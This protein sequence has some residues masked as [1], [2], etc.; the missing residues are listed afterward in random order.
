MFSHWKYPPDDPTLKKLRRQAIAT[1]LFRPV[2]LLQAVERMGFVQA[3]PIRSPA[4][5]QD[6]ILRHRVK[7]Y[8][9][10]DLESQYPRLGLEEDFLYA[11]GFM[12]QS[13]WRLLH[14]RIPQ[15]LSATEKRVLDFVSGLKQIHPRDLDAEFGRK[16]E[17]NNWGGQ[18]QAMTRTLHSL[19]YRGVLRVVE[20]RN[21]IRLYEPV[22]EMHEPLDPVERLRQLTLL[23][24]SILAP[25]PDT[26]LRS[27]VNYLRHAAPALEGRRS[28]VTELIKSG[29]LA[30]LVAD[31]VKYVWPA[32][33]SA[34]R[35]TKPKESVRFLAPFDPLVWDRRRFEHFWNWAYRFEAYTPAAKRQLGYY[36]M[37]MLWRDDVIGWVN[38]VNRGGSSV[39][40]PGFRTVQPPDSEFRTEF[41]AEVARLQVFLKKRDKGL[42]RTKRSSPQ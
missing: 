29:D 12:P 6:L 39:V 31:G 21:G 36:A 14:P 2:S 8:R 28:I 22:I 5:A 26:S 35:N 9:A 11:Y 1:S 20:R 4:R 13:T 30:N 41:E 38:V 40:E 18:S 42:E 7:N 32:A 10:G 17:Q 16:S 23:I 33:T 15:K 19:H 34:I 25:L 27:A 3:D 24:A 37:P